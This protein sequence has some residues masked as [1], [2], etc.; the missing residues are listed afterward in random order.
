MLL[1]FSVENYRSICERQ[2]LSLLAGSSKSAGAHTGFGPDGTPVLPVAMIYWA[3][4]SGKSNLMRAFDALRRAVL[5]SGRNLPGQPLE[6]L[7]PFKFQST[8]V[9][10][11]THFELAFVA[12]GLRY[13]YSLLLDA[14]R[15]SME[16]LSFYPQGREALLFARKHQQFTF[17]E[18]LKGQK[19][20]IAAL[21]APNHL[22]LSKAAENNLA[23]LIPV[24]QF[25]SRTLMPIPLLDNSQEDRY[26]QL[27]MSD[28]HRLGS[29][30]A[31]VRHFHKL[32]HTFDTG[33]AAFRIEPGGSDPES[34]LQV[35][36]AHQ[37]FDEQMASVGQVEHPLEEE[38]AGTQ[39]L[40]V[41][42]A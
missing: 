6:A 23:Q 2:T 15:V 28:L 42:G 30:D 11:P 19:A 13:T 4:A 14:D 25:F 40:F 31:Y 26:K 12:A 34:G 21:T 24:F 27:I 37:A 18:Y 22:F 39:K 36:V 41:L 5:F 16:Q 33:V 3:N 9:P 29:D 20:V 8:A 35:V 7:A 17:S 10:R 1:E 32:L 38:S